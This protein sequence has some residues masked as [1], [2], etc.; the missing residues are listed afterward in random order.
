[1]GRLVA[2]KTLTAGGDPEL[3]LRFRNEAASA[4]K[5][6]HKNIVT[7]Y[8]F[9][10]HEG[11]PYIVMELLEGEDLQRIIASQ[12]HLSLVQKMQIMAEVAQGLQH[13]HSHGVVHRDVK[14]ANIMVLPTGSVKI[15]DFGIALVTHAAGTRL[16]RTGMLPGTLRYMAPEQFRGA[17][18]DPLSDIFSYAITYYELL[19]GQHPFNA[20]TQPAV[21]YRIMSV[22]P[23]P[24]CSICPECPEALEQV[25]ARGLQKERD[26]RYPSLDDMQ[27]DIRPLMLEL[28]QREAQNLLAEAK[29]LADTGQIEAAQSKARESLELDPTNAEARQLRRLLQQETEKQLVRPKIEQLLTTG[30]MKLHAGNYQDAI[31]SL[32]SALR[33]DRSNPSILALIDEARSGMRKAEQVKQLLSDGKQAFQEGNLT[34]AFQKISS[35]REVD[36]ANTETGPLIEEIQRQ[37]AARDRERKLQDGLSK[38]RGAILLRSFEEAVQQLVALETEFAGT[39]EI[40]ELLTRARREQQDKQRR[41]NLELRLQDFRNKIRAG[42]LAESIEGL[43]ALRHEYPDSEELQNLVAYARSEWQT[44][45]RTEAVLR[46]RDEAQRFLQAQQFDA[47]RR[48]LEKGLK[49]Y[50]GE[51][52]LSESLRRVTEA[53]AG[54]ARRAARGQTL[55]NCQSLAAAQR[56]AEAVQAIGQ[57]TASYGADEELARLRSQFLEQQEA[58]NRRDSYEH[59]MERAKALLHRHDPAAAL[60]LLNEALAFVPGDSEASA[61]LSRARKEMDEQ[62]RATDVSRILAEASSFSAQSLFTR[63]ID[64]LNSGLQTYPGEP[65][66]LRARDEASQAKS[67]Q[68]REKARLDAVHKV[69][70]AFAAKRYDDAL[71]LI[72]D[73][74][75]EFG[76]DDGLEALR[77]QI[78]QEQGLQKTIDAIRSEWRRQRYPE[79]LQLIESALAGAPQDA[80]LL[81]LKRQVEADSEHQQKQERIAKVV[82]R[83]RELAQAKEFDKALELLDRGLSYYP[84]DAELLVA[85]DLVTTARS[86][87][88]RQRSLQSSCAAIEKAFSRASFEEALE[89]L[90]AARAEF[91]DEPSL[92]D[93]RRRIEAAR[94]EHR[95]GQE[96]VQAIAAAKKLLASGDPEGA[97][98]HIDGIFRRYPNESTLQAFRAEIFEQARNKKRQRVAGEAEAHAAGGRH[99]EALQLLD[100]SASQFPGD[101]HLAGLRERIAQEQQAIQRQAERHE[102]LV[103]LQGVLE[104][105]QAGA[106]KKQTRELA[107][108]ASSIS[109]AH[110]DDAEFAALYS[111]IEEILRPRPAPQQPP[112]PPKAASSPSKKWVWGGGLAALL[113][114]GAFVAYRATSG[115]DHAT[116][117]IRTNPPGASV[118]V[119][120]N[121]CVTPSCRLDLP[122]G[123][124]Q[125]EISLSGHKSVQQTF[126]LTR[127]RPNPPPIEIAMEAVRTKE[128]P[129][130]P[131]P[132]PTTPQGTLAVSTGVEGVQV[133]LN[134]K[135]YGRTDAQG[136]L[137]LTVEA[138]EYSLRAEKHGYRGEPDRH[139]RVAKDSRQ[140]L[141]LHL[142]PMDAT[143]V[144]QGGPPGAQV[145][146][147]P[148]GKAIGTLSKDGSLSVAVPPGERTI[149]IAR[150]Q[151]VPRQIMKRFEPGETVQL[152]PAETALTPLPKV[153]D[154]QTAI[155]QDWEKARATQNVA[156]VEDFLRRHPN[157]AFTAVAQQMLD[158]L[159][160]KSVNKADSASLRDFASRYSSSRYARE[161]LQAASRIDWDKLDKNNQGALNAYRGL[162]KDDPDAVARAARELERLNRPQAPTG[163]QVSEH[164]PS[165]RN[166]IYAAL[167]RYTTAF[168][169]KDIDALKAA[170]PGIPQTSVDGLKRAFADRNVRMT[171]SLQ[172]LSDP[173]IRGN[174]ATLVCQ[175]STIT[176]QKGRSSNS[177]PRKVNVTLG[178]EGSN[179]VIQNIQNSN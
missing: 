147:M 111:S 42:L 131:P 100:Q 9:G 157:G 29:K 90:N 62:R 12:R 93:W 46:I 11:E 119:D 170:W 31:Q 114:A 140:E 82:V 113:G 53:A 47:A 178:K 71:R 94:E 144:I 17:T 129:P 175:M 56:F 51:D 68:D 155:A 126:T 48:T 177:P 79:A 32:E 107:A 76:A 15:M 97:L 158:D 141:A 60:P 77:T 80:T 28:Q 78:Q 162:Y 3:L 10:E 112:A 66:L 96:V 99:R 95:R 37:I 13:A 117:E 164:S 176:V 106:G 6:H 57:Y 75:R 36:P 145:R 160:W 159:R 102:A 85:R 16:T 65:A 43:E 2:V 39:P 72:G 168:E 50:P 152:T 4:G 69:R 165:E 124:H 70:Q 136:R 5:L 83:S 161:A 73:A 134:G 105:L 33:L 153:T 8:D 110:K 156:A 86:S 52:S 23:E 120:N 127:G 142:T 109:G 74:V 139:V 179:W 40:T 148:E 41:E 30:R 59:L 24:L 89:R 166:A 84:D 91:G 21:M 35:A 151:F 104:K 163:P 138:K 20:A 67:G 135:P 172:T 108:Q 45:M 44:R 92:L 18:N 154:P 116:V 38:A 169:R 128:P 88:E 54:H 87:E 167:A 171:M 149:E 123:E 101:A 27:L 58:R 7:I 133:L 150:D 64:L 81:E 61:L 103:S 26:M 118:R 19:T 63:A 115:P 174:K 122:F 22:D 55:A 121:S 1:M 137:R 25:L 173:E 146:Q 125:L 143:L 98:E 132:A 34:R 49:D 130:P 14:P